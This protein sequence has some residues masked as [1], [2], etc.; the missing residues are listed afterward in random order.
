MKTEKILQHEGKVLKNYTWML[1]NCFVCA[2]FPPDT[3]FECRRVSLSFVRRR[4]NWLQNKHH[5][6]PRVGIS[7]PKR[8]P[9]WSV[10]SHH[11][12][13]YAV[14]Y[15]MF[16]HVSQKLFLPPLRRTPAWWSPSDSLLRRVPQT[17]QWLDGN[18]NHVYTSKTPRISLQA[19]SIHVW[20]SV[21]YNRCNDVAL[22]FFS[23]F[24]CRQEIAG[25]PC[26]YS[27]M[28]MWRLVCGRERRLSG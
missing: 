13:N 16:L 7:R 22:E 8:Q 24:S 21:M 20:I 9:M 26:K 25:S 2:F 17:D 27:L 1:L 10:R 6:R 12:M 3:F 5:H 11:L 14:V 23:S 19:L 4:I 28:S 15:N 18:G